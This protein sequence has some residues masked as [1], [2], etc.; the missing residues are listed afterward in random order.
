MD[1]KDGKICTYGFILSRTSVAPED[2]LQ[3]LKV[4]RGM[5]REGHNVEMFLIGD[6]VWLAKSGHPKS[7]TIVGELLTNGARVIISGDHLKASGMDNGTLVK[8]TEVASKPFEVMVE[9]IMERWDKVY[10]F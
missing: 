1:D 3:I 7:S 9:H 5:Q 6:G 4:A 2:P 8:G 10:S